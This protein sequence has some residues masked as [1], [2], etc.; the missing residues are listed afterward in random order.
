MCQLI[1]FLFYVVVWFSSD[2]LQKRKFNSFHTFFQL[3][4]VKLR[5]TASTCDMSTTLINTSCKLC[6]S[7]QRVGRQLLSFSSTPLWLIV[8]YVSHP[9]VLHRTP[10]VSEPAAQQMFHHIPLSV[11]WIYRSCRRCKSSTQSNAHTETQPQTPGSPAAHRHR[12]MSKT[13]ISMLIRVTRTL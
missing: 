3:L 11:V 6:A 5:L 13:G 2:L 9:S 4:H 7:S 8:S 10:P 12:N 1:I